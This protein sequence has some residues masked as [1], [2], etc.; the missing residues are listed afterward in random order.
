[1]SPDKTIVESMLADPLVSVAYAGWPLRLARGS[2]RAAI[3][4]SQNTPWRFRIA[5]LRYLVTAT[6]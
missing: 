5:A 6:W 3:H 2:S 4:D 1:M